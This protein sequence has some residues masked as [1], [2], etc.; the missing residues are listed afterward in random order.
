MEG[1][2]EMNQREKERRKAVLLMEPLSGLAALCDLQLKS[3]PSLR[4]PHP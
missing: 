1:E 4:S 3:P 2:E